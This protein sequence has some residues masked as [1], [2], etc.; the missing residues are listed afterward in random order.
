M[1]LLSVFIS[2][3]FETNTREARTVKS[4]LKDYDLRG[5]PTGSPEA[6][7]PCGDYIDREKWPVIV[8]ISYSKYMGGEFRSFMRTSGGDF[9]FLSNIEPGIHYFGPGEGFRND[10]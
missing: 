6:N 8:L 5:I 3:K 7:P 4:I 9:V 1:A 10:F 2:Y